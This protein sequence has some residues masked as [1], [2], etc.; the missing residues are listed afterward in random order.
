MLHLRHD[1]T[2]THNDTR[3]GR[4]QQK[5][6]AR[7]HPPPQPTK[8]AQRTTENKQ[9]SLLLP[10]HPTPPHPT[11]NTTDTTTHNTAHN[12]Q[13]T[14]HSTRIEENDLTSDSGGERFRSTNYLICARWSVGLVVATHAFKNNPKEHYASFILSSESCDTQNQSRVAAPFTTARNMSNEFHVLSSLQSRPQGDLTA[15]QEIQNAHDDNS[16]QEGNGK[17]LN[18]TCNLILIDPSEEK[19]L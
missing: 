16:Q 15:D 6:S 4:Q 14:T 7:P 13:H 10:P 1:Q 8:Q 9:P 5:N 18:N 19:R 2:R 12:T 3:R 11:T 17:Q